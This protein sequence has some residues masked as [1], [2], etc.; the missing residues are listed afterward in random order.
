MDRRNS[1]GS[2]RIEKMSGLRRFENETKHALFELAVRNGKSIMLTRMFPP[3]VH[4]EILEIYAG[5]LRIGINAPARGAVASSNPL[6]IVQCIQKFRNLLW[7]DAVFNG[8]KHRPFVGFRLRNH[9]K[10]SPM[11]PRLQRKSE[12]RATATGARS[13]A[14]ELRLRTLLSLQ[15]QPTRPIIC[16]ARAAALPPQLP[17]PLRKS[18]AAIRNRANSPST[19]LPL[20][21]AAPKTCSKKRSRR[22]SGT[23]ASECR[24][25]NVRSAALRWSLH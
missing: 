11:A 3:R 16:C 20:P 22:P 13:R 14:Q 9:R 12:S 1:F 18:R 8:D 19:L 21:G 23:T 25:N 17:H 5:I 7:V 15:K 4:N 10:F 6:V 24:V 2:V